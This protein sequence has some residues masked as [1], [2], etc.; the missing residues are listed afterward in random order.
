MSET[1]V[2]NSNLQHHPIRKL[3]FGIPM[4]M[5]T[6]WRSTDRV[7]SLVPQPRDKQIA[8]S[9]PPGCTQRAWPRR[10][11]LGATAP[12]SPQPP[13]GGTRARELRQPGKPPTLLLVPPRAR[14]RPSPFSR[15]PAR[16]ARAGAPA[17]AAL[18]AGLPGNTNQTLAFCRPPR[19]GSAEGGLRLL[20]SAGGPCDAQRRTGS[21]SHCHCLA[22]P[23]LQPVTT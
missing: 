22:Q 4:Q 11:G 5:Q 21:L 13:S 16:S 17:P 15:A 10:G 23:L 7:R 1:L 14:A 12:R 18:A 3:N 19:A 8:F 9:S 6:A 2:Q 20:A